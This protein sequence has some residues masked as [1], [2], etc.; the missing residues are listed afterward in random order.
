MDVVLR[1][2]FVHTPGTRLVMDGNSIKALREGEPTRRLPLHAIDT[3][4]VLGGVD[5]STPLLLRCAEQERVVA[6][7][8]RYGKPRAVVDGALTGRSHLRRLQYAAHA[9]PDRRAELAGCVVQGKL[10]QMAWAMRQFARSTAPTVRESLRE[11]AAELASATASIP[12]RSREQ[13]LGIEG[14]SSRRY[15]AAYGKVV[16]DNP[17]RGRHR[18]PVTDPINALLSWCY[19]M[20]RISVHGALAVA[21]LDPGTGYLHG[22]RASQ[23]SLVLDLMEEFRPSADVFAAKLWNTR[24]LQ[25]KHFIT[26]VTGSV[27][28][29]ADGREVLFDA[30]HRLR[31]ETVSLKGRALTVPNAMVPIIQAHGMAKALRNGEP[32]E[33]HV[34]VVR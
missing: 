30:W 19:G 17:W 33:A 4:V 27:E 32:Y 28:M 15:F 9:N 20:T 26:G 13:L 12:G 11:T 29:T 21:G 23:P 18:R 25:D 24:Q 2:L 1:T 6:F 3:L 10:E 16:R 22:D 7:L 14:E 31:S 34:R 5:V 8:S